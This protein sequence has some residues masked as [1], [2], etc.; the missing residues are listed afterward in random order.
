MEPRWTEQNCLNKIFDNKDIILNIHA[1]VKNS[2]IEHKTV[3]IQ[4]IWV[5]S[6]DF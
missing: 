5:S 2:I 4:I 3:R 6:F 1:S